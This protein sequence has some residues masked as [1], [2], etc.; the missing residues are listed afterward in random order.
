MIKET[1]KPHG[2]RF[3]DSQWNKLSEVASAECEKT[4]GYVTPSDV[5][6]HAVLKYLNK[7]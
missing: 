5:V 3:S 7:K 6:R 2:I 4:G 1:L